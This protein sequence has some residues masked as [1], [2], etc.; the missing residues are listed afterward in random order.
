VLPAFFA[1]DPETHKGTYGHALVIG[2]SRGM[3][4]APILAAKAAISSGAGLV[5][6]AVPNDILPAAEANVLEALKAGL[7]VDEQGCIK[8]TAAE[9]ALELANGKNVVALG[10]GLGQSAAVKD[11]LLQ[12]L[13]AVKTPLVIDADGLNN[14][15]GHLDRL[16]A[17]KQPMV[18]TP[19]P[20]EA[21]RLLNTTASEVQDDR[22]GAAARLAKETGA[23]I[24]LKGA[25]TVITEPHGRVWINTTGNPGM[26]TGGVGDVLTGLIAGL[27][28]QGLDTLNAAIVGVYLHG[29]AGD[30]AAE[31]TGERALTATHLLNAIPLVCKGLEQASQDE[32]TEED[33]ECTC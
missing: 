7:P 23:V 5:T 2:G 31:T 16:A 6:I 1:R 19:H 30:H 13:S 15:A 29:L 4:G 10:P 11:F 22:L 24:V 28:A 26:A 27:M 17:T 33:D 21:A 25:H 8:E 12:F 14:L 32:S 18:L 9:Q 3:S 20:G